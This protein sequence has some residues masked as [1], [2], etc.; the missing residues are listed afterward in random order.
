[1]KPEVSP[2]PSLTGDSVPLA[3]EMKDGTISTRA[4]YPSARILSPDINVAPAFADAVRELQAAAPT[5]TPVPA[6]VNVARRY[7]LARARTVSVKSPDRAFAPSS[8]SVATYAAALDVDMPATANDHA[9]QASV[10]MIFDFG[11]HYVSF[12]YDAASGDLVVVAPDDGLV[13]RASPP[14]IA[15]LH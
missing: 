11:D 9:P 2:A 5:P 7:D 6:M 15:L 4:Y 1:M 10:Y 12:A 3:L 14:L 13:V 8:S